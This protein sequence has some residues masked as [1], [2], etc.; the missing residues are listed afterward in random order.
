MVTRTLRR[1]KA[2]FYLYCFDYTTQEGIRQKKYEF[3][4]EG[5]VD[6]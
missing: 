3:Q 6:Q 4:T 5:N 2:A 1:G